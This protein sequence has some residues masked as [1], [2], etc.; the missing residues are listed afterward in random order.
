MEVEVFKVEGSGEGEKVTVG[1][2]LPFPLCLQEVMVPV[3]VPVS[4]P[5]PLDLKEENEKA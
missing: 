3:F 5:T 1:G 4:V 2:G